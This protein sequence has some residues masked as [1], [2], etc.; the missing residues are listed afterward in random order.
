[1][2]KSGKNVQKMAKKSGKTWKNQGILSRKYSGHPERLS[3]L[4]L[5]VC[6]L[7]SNMLYKMFYSTISVDVLRIC[8]ATSNYLFFLESVK[9]TYHSNEKTTCRN[10]WD[11]ENSNKDDVQTLAAI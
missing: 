7:C 5:S 9:K 2:R 11:K 6:L 4:M 10:T 3:N 1:M 8:Q